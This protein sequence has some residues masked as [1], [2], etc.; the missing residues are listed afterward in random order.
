[1]RWDLRGCTPPWG[2]DLPA[3]RLAILATAAVIVAEL[4]IEALTAE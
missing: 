4:L 3:S 2:D 1:M